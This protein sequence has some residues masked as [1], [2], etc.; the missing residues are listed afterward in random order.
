MG[1]VL[2]ILDLFQ[3]YLRSTNVTCTLALQPKGSN[4]LKFELMDKNLLIKKIYSP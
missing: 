3:T 4:D 1:L 2:S